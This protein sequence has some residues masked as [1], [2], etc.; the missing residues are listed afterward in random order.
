[1]NEV[2]TRAAELLSDF[3]KF[4]EYLNSFPE[5]HIVGVSNHPREDPLVHYLRSQ[6]ISNVEIGNV[7]DLTTFR[8]GEGKFQDLPDIAISFSQTVDEEAYH[9]ADDEEVEEK[10]NFPITKE[11]ALECLEEAIELSKRYADDS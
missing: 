4:R 2:E 1:M 9:E 10:H 6:G 7:I 5:G 3:D 8:V 11:L